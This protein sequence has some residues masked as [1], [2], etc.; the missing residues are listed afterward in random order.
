MIW[1]LSKLSYGNPDRLRVPMISFD[2]TPGGVIWLVGLVS[3]L[4]VLASRLIVQLHERQLVDQE[5]VLDCY[6]RM[7][8]TVFRQE[9]ER[10]AQQEQ[11]AAADDAGGLKEPGLQ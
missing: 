10:D 7:N 2:A 11:K 6:H 9:A 1:A 4:R 5:W 3:V 8:G